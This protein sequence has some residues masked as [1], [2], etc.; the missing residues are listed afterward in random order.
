MARPRVHDDAVRERLLEVASQAVAERGADGVALRDVASRAGTSTTAVYSLFGGRPELLAAVGEEAFRRF[1]AHLDAAPRTGDPRADLLAL[2][3][4]YRES[5]LADPHFYRIMFDVPGAGARAPGHP[6]TH[7]TPTFLV[8]RDAVRAVVGD[9]PADAS[10]EDAAH[11]L[12]ALV[13]GLVVLELAGLDGG[14]DV[15]A[16]EDR[17]AAT[18][19]RAGAAIV[20]GAAE[21]S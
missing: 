20:A 6:S 17:Y 19:R 3:L 5:A 2:G 12:W 8:L 21:A 16:R 9:S 7:D 15:A 14:R 18:L 1:A 4:A 13:H 10:V 11:A